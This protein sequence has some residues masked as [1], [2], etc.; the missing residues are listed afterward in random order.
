MKTQKKIIQFI[1]LALSSIVI[2][3]SCET[4][5]FD[6]TGWMAHTFRR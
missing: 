5:E 2:L 1:M 6:E 4:H 3:S